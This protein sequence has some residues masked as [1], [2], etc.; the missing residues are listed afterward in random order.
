MAGMFSEELLR[1]SLLV[2]KR[3][4][5]DQERNPIEV[6]SVQEDHFTT[7]PSNLQDLQLQVYLQSSIS[8]SFSFSTKMQSPDMKRL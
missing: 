7:S 1:A 8:L 5:I 6:I 2:P 3:K 4:K